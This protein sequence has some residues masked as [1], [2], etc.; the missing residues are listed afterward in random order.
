[1]LTVKLGNDSMS[2]VQSEIGN[3]IKNKT[4]CL[5]DAGKVIEA[6]LL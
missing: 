3:G 5:V 4:A 1:M 2:L 6:D